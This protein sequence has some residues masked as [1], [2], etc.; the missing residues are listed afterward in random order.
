MIS[1]AFK[2]AYTNEVA[3][4]NQGIGNITKGVK[5][6]AVAVA[7]A[8]GFSGALGSGAAAQGAKHAL[9]N[10]VGGIG[11]NIMLASMK[12]KTDTAQ[13]NAQIE[14]M[15]NSEPTYTAQEVSDTIQSHLGDNPINRSA[16]KQLK[17]VFETL[18]SAKEEGYI[19]KE[20]KFDT[21]IG[22]VEPNSELGKRIT[23]QLSK[24]KEGDK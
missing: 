10:R 20:G 24:E 7:G 1:S 2:S 15:V 21:S 3:Q 14:S 9:A 19:N 16:V 5:T 12:Q 22:D 11:G 6:T 17:T 13:A 23:E 8:L 4:K 18:S